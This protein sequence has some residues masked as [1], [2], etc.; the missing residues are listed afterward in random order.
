MVPFRTFLADVK[1]LG[2]KG[3]GLGVQGP[4]FI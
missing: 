1:D 4:G 3:Q 2:Y